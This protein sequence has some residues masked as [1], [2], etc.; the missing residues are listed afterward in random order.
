MDIQLRLLFCTFISL[1]S[2]T[3]AAQL[4]E[5][6][7]SGEWLTIGRVKYAGPDKASLKF[8]PGGK[9]T[10]YLLLMRDYRYELKEYFSI[11]FKSDGSSLAALYNIM[12]SFFEGDNKKNKKYDKTFSL[13]NTMV[14]IQH[15]K[16]IE[17]SGI[18]LSTGDGHI[19]FSKGEVQKLFGKK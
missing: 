2:I 10:T 16:R 4:K 1:S 18:M 9:D 5:V 8:L 7:T 17:G 3:A 13:G 6:E 15:Y 19:I 11:R 14:H 12:M